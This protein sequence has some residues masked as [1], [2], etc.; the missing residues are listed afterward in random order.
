MD[1]ERENFW[2]EVKKFTP[3]KGIGYVIHTINGSVAIRKGMTSIEMAKIIQFEGLYAPK[4]Y[5]TLTL[6]FDIDWTPHGKDEIIDLIF[7]TETKPT[8]EDE[9]V[10]R[11]SASFGF[12]LRD[13]VGPFINVGEVPSRIK[14]IFPN[15]E[16]F[17]RV[18]PENLKVIAVWESEARSLTASKINKTVLDVANG[19]IGKDEGIREIIRVLSS[20]PFTFING[21]EKDGVFRNS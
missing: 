7:Y 12:P 6:K 9:G 1:A 13:P 15:T 16:L 4:D 11:D 10:I 20:G 14:D 21:A 18:P 5:S 2:N 17:V 19:K 8:D 3:P